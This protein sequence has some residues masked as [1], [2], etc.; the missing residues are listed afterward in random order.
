MNATKY[1]YEDIV[2]IPRG[3]DVS[4]FSEEMVGNERAIKLAQTWGLMDDAA[5][6][7]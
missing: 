6:R 4:V 5:A 3:A 7:W 1:P 2:V